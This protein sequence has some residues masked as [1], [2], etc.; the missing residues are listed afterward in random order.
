MEVRVRRAIARPTQLTGCRQA[1]RLEGGLDATAG[2]DGGGLYVG[3]CADLLGE[4]EGLVG[5]D[6]CLAG[7]SQAGQH[8]AV[9]ARV[10]L[11]ADE[12][13]WDVGRGGLEL[14]RPEVEGGEE[15]GGVGD[16]VAEEEDLGGVEGERPGRV[17]VGGGRV[18]GSCKRERREEGLEI[19]S[20]L[21]F[22]VWASLFFSS[23]LRQREM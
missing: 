19:G 23:W 15:G 9:G 2:P 11:E 18:V 12:D 6:G 22:P 5:G 1:A 3:Q 10:S 16:L 20:V 4:G 13:D 21:S 14:G 17:G 8:F 7:L